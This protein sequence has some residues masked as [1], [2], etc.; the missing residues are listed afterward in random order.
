MPITPRTL[1]APRAHR[2]TWQG[3][4]F[5]ALGGAYCIDRRDRT[6]NSG[7]WGWFTE[8]T[9][10]A[11]Q[12]AAAI[13]GGPA[14]LEG[15]DEIVRTIV[16]PRRHGIPPLSAHT[17]TIQQR[18]LRGVGRAGHS[19]HDS[20]CQASVPSRRAKTTTTNPAAGSAHHQPG[21]VS[22]DHPPSPAGT[23]GRVHGSRRTGPDRCSHQRT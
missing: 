2:W 3:V 10:T 7:R 13:A 14:T 23:W 6:L 17:A 18:A 20:P 21:M 8:E 12:T 11:E 19:W 16:H 1:W 4:R 5:L 22:R 15:S 9:I